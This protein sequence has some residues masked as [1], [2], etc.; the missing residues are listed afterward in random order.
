MVKLKCPRCGWI[1]D[2]KGK[3]QYYAT[4][5][6]CFRKVNIAKRKVE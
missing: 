2:Y 6:N 5:P 3:K 4:C 1:W